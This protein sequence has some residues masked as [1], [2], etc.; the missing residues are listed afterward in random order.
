MQI[1]IKVLKGQDCNLEVTPSTTIYQVKQEIEERLGIPLGSQKIL[2][3]GRTLNDDQT[4]ASYPNIK[5]GTKLNLIV[6]KQDI[7][8][9]IH[10]SFRKYYNETQSA[11]LTKEF[12]LDFE[13]KL[14][15]FSL[16]DIERL[17]SE[18]TV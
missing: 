4:I 8:D 14:K 12:M 7:K 16:D 15:G 17:A 1:T 11:A 5:E 9:I 10:R 18:H 6:V 2:I 3:L 13:K